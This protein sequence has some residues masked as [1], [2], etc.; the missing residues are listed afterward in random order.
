[1]KIISSLLPSSKDLEELVLGVPKKTKL[2]IAMA[3]DDVTQGDWL[4][5]CLKQKQ[6]NLFFYGRMEEDFNGISYDLFNKVLK[7]PYLKKC[8]VFYSSPSDSPI[9]LHA[10]VLFF[11]NYGAYV[12]SAN[13]TKR[14]WLNNVECGN[15]YNKKDLKKH[16][17]DLNL[18]FDKLD[19][20]PL[21]NDLN[22]K[23]LNKLKT[24]QDN[25]KPKALKKDKSCKTTTYKKLFNKEIKNLF[26]IDSVQVAKTVKL[27]KVKS[28]QVS[29]GR[30]ASLEQVNKSKLKENSKQDY[31]NTNRNPDEVRANKKFFEKLAKKLRM[32]NPE[33]KISY[34]SANNNLQITFQK[35]FNH[36]TVGRSK[37][38]KHNRVF[39][40]WSTGKKT[41]EKDIK[42]FNRIKRD[43]NHSKFW[44][45]LYTKEHNVSHNKREPRGTPKY[46]SKKKSRKVL[47][48]RETRGDIYSL[49]SQQEQIKFLKTKF[50][51]VYK[52]MMNLTE[53]DRR[54]VA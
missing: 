50:N 2:K 47:E 20:H 25:N 42:L 26:K 53:K 37:E 1:M 29:K 38:K 31:S 7:Y 17:E 10:K 22:R 15:W 45:D 24:F 21:C 14:A 5:K 39:V 19:V 46:L 32:D 41:Y 48:C 30:L 3:Y 52:Y 13:L 54:K 11:E 43:P 16:A 9:S 28:A 44:E 49:S 51:K 40:F 8:K 4:S 36:I 27:A 6:I 18:F 23:D 33:L 34:F 12:G 35:G